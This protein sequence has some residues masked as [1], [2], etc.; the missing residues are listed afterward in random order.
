[1][2]LGGAPGTASFL[3]RPAVLAREK[4]LRNAHRTRCLALG[5]A[6]RVH[7]RTAS[8]TSCERGDHQLDHIPRA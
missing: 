4:V 2:S 3:L 6:E 1:M 5:I 8:E 7:A